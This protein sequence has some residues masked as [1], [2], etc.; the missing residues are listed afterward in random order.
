M[1]KF[2]FHVQNLDI[3]VKSCTTKVQPS[4]Q[5]SDHNQTKPDG[6]NNVVATIVRN[7]ALMLPRTDG[8]QTPRLPDESSADGIK[9]NQ[10]RVRMHR[11]KS[12]LQHEHGQKQADEKRRTLN[13]PG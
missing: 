11:Q 7:A 1:M 10:Q 13:L 9:W 4:S 5:V 8:T 3:R 12:A 6:S 2:G